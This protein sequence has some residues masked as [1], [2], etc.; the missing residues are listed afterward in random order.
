MSAILSGAIDCDVHPQ[1]PGIK[2]LVPYL[3]D[4]W[5]E[6][7][8][9]RGIEGFE[10][11]SYPPL[12]PL[13]A[14]PD[15]RGADGRAAESPEPV[16]E[17]L[18]GRWGE[19]HAILNCL[20]GV[21]QIMDERLAAAAAGAV[22]A[23][24]AKEWLD[25]EPRFR[26]SIVIPAQNP[27]LAVEE[28]ERRGADHRFVQILMLVMGDLP[29]GRRFYWPIYAAAERHGLPVAIH[30]GSA[31]RQAPTALGWPSTYVEDYV[32]QAQAFQ[33]QLGSLVSHGV[34]NQHPGLKVVLSESGITW[35]PPFMWRFSKNWRGLRMEIPWVD[36]API[37]I[38]REHVRL[39][40]Q[41]IDAPDGGDALLR[42]I[43]H[44]GSEDML[45]YSSDYP[46]WQFDGDQVLPD[47][48]PE[49]LRRKI[50]VE[51][52]RSTYPRIGGSP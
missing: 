2:A 25:V 20:Y 9:V 37:E 12:A 8:E 16:A 44:L 36:R 34:F 3:D 21:Q 52:P 30:L 7:V 35:L 51:N 42:V 11:R 10:L 15:W 41:P 45:L 39:T 27:D 28:I 47:G 5:Q 50:L 19:S 43:E 4:Y 22:N 26:A 29:L 49:S 32:H 48:I 1:V 17:Q 33:G 40:L 24:I 31:Y 6:M 38:I 13:T 23:W 14:R 18:F 46:H